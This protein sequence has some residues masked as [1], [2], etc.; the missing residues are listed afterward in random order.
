V[1][2]TPSLRD[3]GVRMVRDLEQIL[4]VEQKRDA[5]L[6]AAALLGSVG[7]PASVAPLAKLLAASAD[8]EVRQVAGLSIG[9]I[10]GQEAVRILIDALG[11]EP[12][13]DARVRL[14]DALA[15]PG[16]AEASGILRRVLT[17]T[18]E[19][20]SVRAVAAESLGRLGSPEAL[21][22]LLGVLSDPEPEIRFF[23]AYALGLVGSRDAL[24]ALSQLASEDDASVA[25]L[26]SVAE[27][28]REAIEA[29]LSDDT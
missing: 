21:D 24:D 2:T 17:D 6:D 1:K 9:R 4:G 14:V 29:I 7:R 8:P 19:A 11:S 10:G 25:G 23:A 27:E 20:A 13:I 22:D 26:G 16:L 28:A 5:V 18:G 12:C 15:Y 3:R